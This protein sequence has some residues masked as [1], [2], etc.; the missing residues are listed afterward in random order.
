MI[1]MTPEVKKQLLDL[2]RDAVEN[3]EGPIE[4]LQKLIRVHSNEVI[5]KEIGKRELPRCNII[6]KYPDEISNKLSPE[7]L[8]WAL[9]LISI[10]WTLYLLKR[11]AIEGTCHVHELP[12]T[13]SQKFHSELFDEV[14]KNFEELIKHDYEQEVKNDLGRL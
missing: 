6:Y 11:K 9:G 2:G 1:E 8:M 12:C 7:L 14:Q 10:R 4:I 13:D 3:E 5:T